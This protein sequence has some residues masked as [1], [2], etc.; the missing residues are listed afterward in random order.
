[1]A[2]RITNT[3]LM[4]V[5]LLEECNLSCT[6]C[7]REEEPMR[8]GYRLSMS[9][10]RGC[11]E[12]C[13]V[14]DSIRWVHF[15]GGEPTLWRESN[16]DLVDLLVEISRNGFDPGF[17]SNGVLLRDYERCDDLLSRYF[18]ESKTTLR[19]YLSVDTFHGNFDADTGR[20]DCLDNVSRWKASMSPRKAKHLSVT[21]LTVISRD[22]ASLLPEGMVEHYQGLG[23][24][25]QFVP[26]KPV[27]RARSFASLCPD[28]TSD[29]PEDLGAFEPYSRG[30]AIQ[31][32]D[33]AANMVLIGDDYYLPDP[34]RRV[35]RM[36]ELPSDMVAAYAEDV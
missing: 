29:R 3:S 8:P 31:D 25:F 18:E 12:D 9:Q 23:L 7:V 4:M 21:V 35:A 10:L 34:W 36:G 27:G 2:L 24:T 19:L 15:S 28:T 14:L 11:L 6:H 32:P 5:F 1:M 13:K 16:M 20:S 33:E 22:P 17:T 30:R 26:L